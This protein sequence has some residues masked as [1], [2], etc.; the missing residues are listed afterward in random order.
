MYAVRSQS[1]HCLHFKIDAP[2]ISSHHLKETDAPVLFALGRLSANKAEQNQSRKAVYIL[3]LCDIN[4]IRSLLKRHGFR[5]SKSMG[6]NFLIDAQIPAEIAAASKADSTC[7]VLEIGPG[8]GSLTAEL[9]K[10]A[11]KVVSVE[12]DQRLLPVLSETLQSVSNVQIIFGD[13]M[14]LD[15]EN[16][17]AEFFPGLTPIVCANLPYNITTPVLEKLI[18]T[19]CFESITV[20]IQREVAKRLCAPPGSS[21]GGA[22]SLFLQYYMKPV[23]L[24][25]VGPEKFIPSPKVSSAVIHCTR[26]KQPAVQLEAPIDETLFFRVIRG[27]FLLRR[28]TLV[29]SLSAAF[30]HLSK[31]DLQTAIRSCSLP[32]N[33]RG[34]ALTLEQFAELT[35]QIAALNTTI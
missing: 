16:L 24:F 12:L 18:E 4:T 2:S 7:A 25:D 22:F 3:N 20:M 10:R 6:Q 5:F 17:T 31:S 29:N 13:I 8:I 26:R 11:N 33:I 35:A 21:D 27:A 15:L 19:P 30:S 34:E 14:K 9:A 1:L 23:Y 28:K 32:E